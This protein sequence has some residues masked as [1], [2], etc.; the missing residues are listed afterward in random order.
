MTLAATMATRDVAMTISSGDM[1]IL[2]HGPTFMGNPL[3]CAVAS[4]SLDILTNSG[5]GATYPQGWSANVKRIEH[6]LKALFEIMDHAAIADVRVLGAIGV[7]E[8]KAPVDVAALQKRFVEK[9]VWVRPFAHL[10][11]IMPPYII[12][13]DQLKKICS[14]IIETIDELY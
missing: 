12:S 6:G 2:M 1:P 9:G 13:D 10:I 8:M 14:A 11:Y 5:S 4:A 3:A 7:V